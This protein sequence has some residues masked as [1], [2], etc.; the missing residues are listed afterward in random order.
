[1]SLMSSAAD[2]VSLPDLWGCYIPYQKTPVK[3]DTY[4]ID[5]EK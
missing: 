5:R 3:T 4:G 1:M 2:L